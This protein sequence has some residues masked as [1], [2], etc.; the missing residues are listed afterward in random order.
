MLVGVCS[1]LLV[2][3]V[4]SLLNLILVQVPA[5]LL[6]QLSEVVA[7]GIVITLE[8]SV[9]L[10]II[11]VHFLFELSF[12][13]INLLLS[14][15]LVNLCALGLVLNTMYLSFEELTLLNDFTRH[16]LD[17]CRDFL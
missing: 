8:G 9:Q 4:I 13:S 11:F 12:E 5:L 1:I 17:L 2:T 6:R 10:Q 15:F 7:S 14:I 3:V 16:F